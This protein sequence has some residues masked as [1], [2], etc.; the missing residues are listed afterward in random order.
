MIKKLLLSSVLL[1]TLLVPSIASASYVCEATYFVGRL[2][3][4]LS[5]TASCG[6]TLTTYWL[7]DPS[8]TASA[9]SIAR[10]STAELI[11]VFNALSRAADS[12]QSVSAGVTNCSNGSGTTCLYYV[13]FRN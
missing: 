5:S 6:G 11:G 2:R 4:I 1:G 12:Q 7:C 9:C 3:T 8:S 10:Y 13:N